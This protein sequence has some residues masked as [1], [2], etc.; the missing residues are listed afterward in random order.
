MKSR[1]RL[2]AIIAAILIILATIPLYGSE[3]IISLFLLTLM[4]VGLAVSWII[5]SGYTGYINLAVAAFFGLGVYVS[6]IF[7][8]TLPLPILIIIGGMVS[9]IFAF[10]IGLP[11]LRTRGPY[12]IIL[13]LGLSELLKFVAERYE[14]QVRGSLGNILLDTPSL[15]MLYY[16]I[17]VIAILTILTAH[18]I[19]NSKFGLGLLSIKGNEEAAESMGLN[20]TKF[21][22][23]AFAISAF[24]MG[25]IGAVMALQWTFVEPLSAFNPLLTF[26]VTIMAILGGIEDFRG[27]V[28]GATILALISEFLGIKF[29]YYYLIILGVILIVVIKLLP[30]GLLGMISKLYVKRQKKLA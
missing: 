1:I 5:F 24:F 14:A 10:F 3:Y 22:I 7:W 12:F 25:C 11:C 18:F 17:M 15:E 26:Q 13:T 19:K 20:A 9:A 23:T 6:V 21:K 16:A 29:V 2:T 30:G 4:Y 8:P 28:I 27:P